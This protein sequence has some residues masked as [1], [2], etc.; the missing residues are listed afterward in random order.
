MADRGFELDDNLPKGVTLNI[1]LFHDGRKQ[2]NLTDEILTYEH[3]ST[4]SYRLCL[5]YQMVPDL[6]KSWVICCYL[7][8]SFPQL[9][10][11]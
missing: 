3:M 1:P 5:N 2:L 10:T 8:K 6:N 11:K 9:V 7:V 4:K